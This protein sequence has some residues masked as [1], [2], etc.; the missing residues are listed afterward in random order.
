MHKL[1]VIISILMLIP[2]FSSAEPTLTDF[3]ERRAVWVLDSADVGLPVG[4][5]DTV[6]LGGGVYRSYV[7]ASFQSAGMIDQ[8]GEP[9]AFPGCL[10]HYTSRDAGRT[11]TQAVQICDIPCD[12]CPCLDA[13]DH[14]GDRPDGTRAAAQQY[15]RVAVADGT[16]YLAYEWHAQTILRRSHDGLNWSDWS[17]LLT[18]GGTW[19]LDFAPCSEIER[20]GVHPFVQDDTYDCL[21]GAPPGVYVED[22]TLY[23]FV[24]AGSSPAHMRCYKGDRHGDLG[25]LEPCTTDPLFSGAATYG[26][27]DAQGAAANPYFDFRTISSADVVYQG[28]YYYMAY[29]G[30]RGPGPG[31]PGDTQFALGFARS[32]ALDAS[33]ETYPGSPILEDVGFHFGIGHADLIVIDGVTYMYTSTSNTTRGRYRL[34][35]Q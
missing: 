14:H 24:A 3:W 30:I 7:H 18:P 15:P 25:A 35:W 8:C 5:S 29:E 26:P 20:I 27:L 4:E 23:V 9:V 10:T 11:F 17:Y 1:C 22:E 21:V 13:R 34:E 6:H 19:P 12:A 31:D 2:A 28:G 16:F 32:V 33:W